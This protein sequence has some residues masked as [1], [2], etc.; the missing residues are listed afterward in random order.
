LAEDLAAEIVELRRLTLEQRGQLIAAACRAAAEIE[1]SR[2]ENG[3][4]P[5]VSAPWPTSTWEF[6][7][8]HARHD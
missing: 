5:S 1:R 7:K 6:L 8:K 3:L 2:R 4:P